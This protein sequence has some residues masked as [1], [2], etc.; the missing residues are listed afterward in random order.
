M[1]IF[2]SFGLM[3]RL[4][5]VSKSCCITI[6]VVVVVVA[7]GV[8][9]TTIEADAPALSSSTALIVIIIIITVVIFL[10]FL[11]EISVLALTIAVSG[12]CGSYVAKE[13]N[14]S[15]GGLLRM[16]D[17]GSYQKSPIAFG[18]LFFSFWCLRRRKRRRRRQ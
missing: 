10:V 11:G 14:S 3:S 1:I 4:G 12:I 15:S 16:L 5:L 8:T 2:V 9:E 7:V 13:L 17:I 18:L 6:L